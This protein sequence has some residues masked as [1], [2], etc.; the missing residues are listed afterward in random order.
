[1]A[2]LRQKDTGPK[3]AVR[4]MLHRYRCHTGVPI[5][6]PRTALE[7]TVP[8]VTG[9][10]NPT[11]CKLVPHLGL[12]APQ[13]QAVDKLWGYASDR[14]RHIREHQTVDHAEAELIV[15]AAGSACAFQASRP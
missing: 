15:A 5:P 13:D 4:R 2:S 6:S 10:P 7:T 3:M 14:G 9:Q 8:D 1:M 12:Q 11:S